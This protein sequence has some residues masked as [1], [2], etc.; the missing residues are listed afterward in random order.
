MNGVSVINLRA[1]LSFVC[2]ESEHVCRLCLTTTEQADEVSLHETVKIER[3]YM[4]ETITFVDM[5]LE[6]DVS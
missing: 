4:D 2:G 1:A 6:L 3:A 5:L